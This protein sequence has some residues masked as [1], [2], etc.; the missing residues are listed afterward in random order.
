MVN[1]LRWVAAFRLR[2]TEILSQERLKTADLL[3]LIRGNPDLADE[4]KGAL[5]LLD[6]I[7]E[8]DIPAPEQWALCLPRRTS[9]WHEG[10]VVV[11]LDEFQYTRLPQ[12]RFD[13]VG[14]MQEAVESPTCPHFVTGSAMSILANEI[15]GRGSLFGRFQS[16]P[17][18]PMTDYWSAELALRSARYC[19]A[20]LPEDIAPLVSARCGGNPFYITAVVRQSVKRNKRLTGEDEINEILAVDLS[21]GFIWAE[22]ND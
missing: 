19:K 11:F 6:A 8:K 17:I 2:N 21:S 3:D 15:L 16:E 4:L 12:Y 13:I 20:D 18:K 22:L 9:D 1:F 14:L 7:V 5:N 10:T